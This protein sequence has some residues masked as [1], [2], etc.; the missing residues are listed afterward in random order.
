MKSCNCKMCKK[1]KREIFIITEAT[2]DTII[3][4]DGAS[5][6]DVENIWNV[7]NIEK[8]KKKKKKK[9]TFHQLFCNI[10]QQKYFTKPNKYVK[11]SV[12]KYTR[13]K[14]RQKNHYII[15]RK[16]RLYL[17]YNQRLMWKIS[18]TLM[19]RKK[20]HFDFS[21]AMVYQINEIERLISNV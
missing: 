3:W 1:K 21:S 10:L 4:S 11:S 15:T 2:R 6:S 12:S 9:K 14:E 13:K 5:T 7:I 19:R 8:Q 20:K 16:A 18:A 17:Q